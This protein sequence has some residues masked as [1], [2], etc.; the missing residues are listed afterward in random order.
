MLFGESA[1]VALHDSQFKNMKGRGVTLQFIRSFIA[2]L[3]FKL[4]H[5]WLAAP[6]KL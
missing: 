3:L 5:F 4:A 2:T 1:R 6:Q